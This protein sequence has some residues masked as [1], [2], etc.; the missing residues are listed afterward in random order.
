M[1]VVNL[2]EGEAASSKDMALA[3]TRP[4]LVLDGAVAAALALGARDLH[5]VL[6]G[7]RPRA[8]AGMQAALAERAA[9]TAAA[10]LRVHSRTAA[11]RF[12]AGQARAVVELLDGRPNLPVTAWQPEAV[13]RVHGRP[14]LLSNAE[15]WAHVG[16]LALH[17][18]DAYA[19]HGTAAEVGTTLLTVTAAGARPEVHEVAFGSRMRDV[20]PSWAAGSPAVVGGFHGGWATW[21][22]LASARVSVPGLAALG[23]PL[24]AG[25]VLLPGADACPVQVTSQI[26]GHLAGETSGR[27]GPCVNGLP[28]LADAVRAVLDGRAGTARVTELAGLVARRGACAHP[29]GTVRLVRSLLHTFG[30]E[31]EAHRTAAVPGGEPRRSGWPREP[32]AGRLA[33]LPGPGAVPRAAARGRRPRR[34][35]LPARRAA[36]GH[37]RAARRRP[38]RRARLPAAG[39][40]DRRVSPAARPVRP[41]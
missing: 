36:T 9:E 22:T 25:V 1:V 21:A 18:S 39:A 13:S 6:P 26:V 29:D 24:G 33:G 28:A 30:E 7:E 2:A 10:G 19:E 31:I 3:L 40:A 17:G 16:L 8:A 35:G 15:T 23:V 34:V 11:S 20:L 41:R 32:A 27:C 4:H 38:R 5:V 37:A 12:V 14:T